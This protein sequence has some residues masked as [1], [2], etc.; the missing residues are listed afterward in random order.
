MEQVS[1]GIKRFD[2]ITGGG[3]VRGNTIA[4]LGPSGSGKTLFSEVLSINALKS[5]LP[6]VYICADIFPD[7]FRQSLLTLGINADEYIDKNLLK[8]VDAFSWRIGK[9]DIEYDVSLIDMGSII[10]YMN[11]TVETITKNFDKPPAYIIFDSFSSIIDYNSVEAAYKLVQTL[12]A[13]NKIWKSVILFLIPTAHQREQLM[14]L[15]YPCD[16]VIQFETIDNRRYLQIVKLPYTD[17]LHEKLELVLDNG[18]LILGVKR[19]HISALVSAR[20]HLSVEEQLQE[21]EQRLK[22][23]VNKLRE[24]R[25]RR[26]QRQQR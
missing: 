17:P 3:F 1:S 9:V 21:K 4:L 15:S 10:P 5:G 25:S 16:G 26:E 8:V 23:L 12:K 2:E 19:G 14:K 22:E 6:V 20:K 18:N 24:K 13:H 7:D 11:K